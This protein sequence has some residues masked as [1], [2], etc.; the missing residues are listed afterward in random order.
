[1]FTLFQIWSDYD[2]DAEKAEAPAEEANSPLKREYIDVI[3][4]DVRTSSGL[5]FSVQILNTEGMYSAD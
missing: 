5:S 1:L 4:S 2:E 3:V